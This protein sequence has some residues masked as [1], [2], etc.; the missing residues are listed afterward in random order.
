LLSPIL[1]IYS[2]NIF[3]EGDLIKIGDFGE[4]KLKEHTQLNKSVKGTVPYM[5]PELAS[6]IGYKFTTDIW[7][8][9]CILYEMLTFEKAYNTYRLDELINM[10][11]ERDIL[12]N[13]N[14]SNSFF[15]R[16]LIR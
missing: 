7:S 4:A 10:T 14:I 1:F 13:A 2:N 12:K 5:S 6:K 15:E 11:N 16:L 9:G 8:A 3:L